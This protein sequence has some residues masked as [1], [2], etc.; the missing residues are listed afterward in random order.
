MIWI[1]IQQGLEMRLGPRKVAFTQAF[2]RNAVARK[3]VVGILN[4]RLFELL[5]PAFVLFVTEPH[6][7][8]RLLGALGLAAQPPPGRPVPAA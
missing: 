1:C 8:R 2:K 3:R 5:P 6:A 7:V 4:E